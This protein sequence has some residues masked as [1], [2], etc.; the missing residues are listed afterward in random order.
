MV[1]KLNIIGPLIIFALLS[2]G[3]AIAA[4]DADI[5][6]H[7]IPAKVSPGD[8]FQVSIT[9]Q[10]TS[11]GGETWKRPMYRLLSQTVPTNIWGP[12]QVQL[13]KKESV[14]PGMTATFNMIFTAPATPGI[15]PCQ[16]QMKKNPGST[17][18]ELLNLTVE[19]TDT[20]PKMLD[21]EVVSHTIPSAMCAGETRS[22]TI[23][24]RNTGSTTIW[25]KP[26][27]TLFAQNSPQADDLWGP[28]QSLLNVGETIRLGTTKTFTLDITA[29]ITPGSYNCNW[30]MN[31]TTSEDT[32]FFGEKLET[33]V[34][35]V[36][37]G[38][39]CD[40]GNEC[41]GNGTCTGTVCTGAGPVAD[42]TACNVTNTCTAYTCTGGVCGG[43]IDEGA[44]CN[45][46]NNCTTGDTCSAEGVCTGTPLD[47]SGLDD[48]CNLGVCN[49]YT[50]PVSC[51]Q[52]STYKNYY[53]CSDEIFCNGNDSCIAGTC[54]LSDGDPCVDDGLFCTGSESCAEG[55]D[56]CVSSGDPCTEGMLCNEGADTCD[57]PQCLVDGDCD[58]GLYCT[59][60]ETCVAGYCQPGTPVDC[61]DDGMFCNG[62]ASCGAFADACVSSGNP[63][64][65]DLVCDEGIDTCIGCLQDSDC[66]DGLYCNGQETCVAG[67]CQLGTPVDCKDSMDCTIESCDETTDNCIHTPDNTLCADDQFCNGN[68]VCDP[69]NGCQPGTRV[70]CSDDGAFC[71]GTESCD[72]IA[73]ACVSNGN[74]C[75]EGTVCNEGETTCDVTGCLV[76]EDCDDGIYCN[77]VE[78]CVAYKCQPGTTVDCN[79]SLDCTIENCDEATDNCIHTPDNTLCDDDQFCNGNE[80]CDPVNGCQPG[81]PVNCPDD[82]LF[83]TGA[84]S[85]DEATD[86]CLSSG[87]VCAEGTVCNEDIDFCFVTPCFAD[88]DCGDGIYCNGQE[89]CVANNCQTG[90]PV[91]CNDSVDCT[92][93][94]CDEATDSCIQTPDSGLCNDGQFCNGNE[95]C[96]P[97]NGCQ[98]GNPVDCPDDGTFCNGAESC[99]EVTNS[100]FS[101]G[102]PCAEGTVC[103]EEANTCDAT[104]CSIVADC[105]DGIYCNGLE[106]CDAGT[107]IPGTPVNCLSDGLFC[108]GTESCNEAADSCAGSGNPCPGGTTCN[109]SLD[110]CVSA[111][112]T[113]TTIPATTTTI[114]SIT[115]TTI[116]TAICSVVIAPDTQ[117]VES[118][119]TFEFTAVTTCDGAMVDGTYVWAIVPASVIGS[120]IDANT[121]LYTAGSNTTASD[122]TEIVQVTD[123]AHNTMDTA[124]AVVTPIQPVCETVID[125]STA[126]IDSEESITFTASTEG[127]GC[128]EPDYAWQIDTDLNSRINAGGA[129]CFYQAGTNK[130]KMLHTD[131]LTVVDRANGTTAEVAVTVYYGRIKQVIPGIIRSSRWIPLPHIIYIMGEDTEF[132]PTSWP[133]FT[134]VGSIMTIAKIGFRNFMAAL[135][136]VSPN[137]EQGLIDLAVPMINEEGQEVTFGKEDAFSIR[138]LPFVL[139]EKENKPK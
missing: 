74:P 7:T 127:V 124:E 114:P 25:Y 52:D 101:N 34:S 11:T 137:A 126:T 82:V 42:G 86:S 104:E 49:P 108:N 113:T 18:G 32:R 120:S 93:D 106:T 27:F 22:I 29:P 125:P 45:D 102:N 94:S 10:N 56:Q 48:S 61:P 1:K 81:I 54:I 134:P 122:M 109:E 19:V 87:N 47:C 68:E 123:I 69:V 39:T 60:L 83:C 12:S 95:S 111:S 65:S 36:D 136:L 117:T 130:T 17:F 107:C 24:M 96:D 98:T 90:A 64:P 138:L 13:G 131:T 135:V 105:D 28:S 66:D 85:C 72:E 9:V 33:A 118:G 35:V 41:T 3:Q 67:N 75:A 70:D 121:G 92:A 31:I 112:T 139:D 76:D 4:L 8:V 110:R 2:A 62:T 51:E 6:S 15:Y 30:Q 129:S 37:E 59:G 58:D 116:P 100:C 40:D 44:P 78:T 89:T 99:N 132:N 128:L 55:T 91:N 43:T 73:D 53:A 71:N 57:V 16:W 20:T 88:A 97:V 103:N 50:D 14:A 133:Y 84:E 21:A 115:T 119:E 38:G 5:I 80:V 26:D 46:G 79:D 63:C 23:T 77:G